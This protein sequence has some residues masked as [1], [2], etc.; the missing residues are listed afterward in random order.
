MRACKDNGEIGDNLENLVLKIKSSLYSIYF[1][2]KSSLTPYIFSHSISSSFLRFLF[3]F[4]STAC[5][6]IT[7]VLKF[8]MSSSLK[9]YTIQLYHTRLERHN[10]RNLMILLQQNKKRLATEGKNVEI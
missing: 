2:K 8:G 1:F 6:R 7:H 4:Q 5:M 10:R 3:L 9:M